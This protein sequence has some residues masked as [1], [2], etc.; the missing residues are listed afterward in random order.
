MRQTNKF[1]KFHHKPKKKK[2]KKWIIIRGK[3]RL[4]TSNEVKHK[5]LRERQDRRITQHLESNKTV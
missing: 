5:G 4:Q 1:Y 3:R 2:K